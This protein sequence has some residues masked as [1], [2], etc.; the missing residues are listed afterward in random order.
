MGILL[1]IRTVIASAKLLTAITICGLRKGIEVDPLNDQVQNVF[2]S[3][4]TPLPAK[5][6]TA[7]KTNGETR[8]RT[9]SDT[10]SA[11]RA[12]VTLFLRKPPARI[13]LASQPY[14]SS[15]IPLYERGGK[16]KERLEL[17]TSR[18][19][20]ENSAI[21]LLQHKPPLRIELRYL[22]YRCSVLP[23]APRRQKTF[24]EGVEP[25]LFLVRSQV[26]FPLGEGNMVSPL[27]IQPRTQL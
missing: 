12:T 1:A 16:L 22:H 6:R 19:R 10:S 21:E 5:N 24:P 26:P 9:G 18:L 2:Y 7:G 23:L 4:H 14:K 20:C 15:I 8:S 17:S 25:P 27:G 13:E 3:S 11:C